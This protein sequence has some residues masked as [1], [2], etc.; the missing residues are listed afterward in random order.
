MA[1]EKLRSL[2]LFLTILVIVGGISWALVSAKQTHAT[3]QEPPSTM[4]K[5]TLREDIRDAAINYIRA[6]HDDAAPFLNSFNLAWTGG[7]IDTGLLG[8]ETYKYQ[9]PDWTVT[10]QYPVVP[11]PRYSIT[12]E[13][14]AQSSS[15]NLGIPYSITWTGTWQNGIIE[16][17]YILVQ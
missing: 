9:S 13:Y 15:G 10:L 7:R 16:T 17:N 8:G 4:P 2:G 1:H 6:N 12:A 5:L 11:N 14:S 3:A